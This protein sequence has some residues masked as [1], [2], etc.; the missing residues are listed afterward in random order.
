MAIRILTVDDSKVIRNQLTRILESGGY[1]VTQA[2]DGSEAVDICEE[3]SFDLIFLDVNMPT[4]GIT[5][6]ERIRALPSH[7][8]TPVCFLTT[9]GSK[10]RRDRAKEL[11]AIAWIVKPFKKEQ[12]LPTV[13]AILKRVSEIA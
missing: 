1:D 6:L 9:E 7:I 3:K 2:C 11:G 10:D 12:L 5:A 8:K 4:P 13:A